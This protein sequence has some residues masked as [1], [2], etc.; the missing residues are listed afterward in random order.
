MWTKKSKFL[1]LG[2]KFLNKP[3]L[4]ILNKPCHHHHCYLKFSSL[5]VVPTIDVGAHCTAITKWSQADW[6]PK[7]KDMRGEFF[8]CPG[9]SIPDLGQSLTQCHFWIL[10]Q[11]VTF[12]TLDPSDIWS[13]R[14]KDKK[15]KRQKDKKQRRQKYKKYKKIKKMKWRK[16][17]KMKRQKYEKPKRWKDKK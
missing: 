6:S 13:E 14:Q 4:K 12:E 11:R 5:S 7:E 10:T 17:E 9:S 2:L 8:S 1:P 3:W 16:E 15:T